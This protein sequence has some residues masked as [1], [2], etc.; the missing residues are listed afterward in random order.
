MRPLTAPGPRYRAL[1]DL[2]HTTETVWEASRRFFA[3]WQ[4][5]P[6]QFNILN[7]LSENRA[8]HTQIELSRRLI[9]HRSNITGLVDRLESRGLVQRRAVAGDRRAYRVVLSPAGRK[10]L[11]QILP[12]YYRAAEDLWGSV[13]GTTAEQVVRERRALA[14]NA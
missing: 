12:H 8:G 4:L 2:L 11:R 10:L 6:S 9:M 13:P 7:L 14:E 3:R 5:S 1:L